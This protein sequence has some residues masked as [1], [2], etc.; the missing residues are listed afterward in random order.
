MGSLASRE[1]QRILLIKPS[2]AGDVAHTLPVLEKL[3]GRYPAARID[4]LITP[5]NAELIRCHPALSS[6]VLFDRRRFA[7]FGRDWTATKG[8]LGLLRTIRRSR[9]EMVVDLHGQL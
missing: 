4:W 2:A 6:V 5:E 8:M 3:R 1:F 9:Y 7:R